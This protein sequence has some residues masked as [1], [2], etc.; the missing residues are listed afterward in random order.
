[1]WETVRS[2]LPLLQIGKH[3][4]LN[5]LHYKLHFVIFSHLI[6]YDQNGF[7]VHAHVSFHKVIA[8]KGGFCNANRIEINH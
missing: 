6:S 7:L 4:A 8:P 1:M 3:Y 2:K 5:P